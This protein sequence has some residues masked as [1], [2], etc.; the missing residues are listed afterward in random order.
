ML[1]VKYFPYRKNNKD[2][3]IWNKIIHI[4]PFVLNVLDNADKAFEKL[5]E[6]NDKIELL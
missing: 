4:P 5:K 2:D 3:K 1:G 6:Y